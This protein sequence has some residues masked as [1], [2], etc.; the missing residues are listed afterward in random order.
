MSVQNLQ[1][2]SLFMYTPFTDMVEDPQLPLKL[3]R[4]EL[5]IASSDLRAWREAA[6][7]EKQKLS[8]WIRRACDERMARE[9]VA[10]EA[11]ARELKKHR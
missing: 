8:E 7:R 2:V 3:L 11:L 6:V 10:R 9:V 5:R 4:V 1:I